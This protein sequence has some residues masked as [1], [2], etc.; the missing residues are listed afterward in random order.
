MLSLTSSLYTMPSQFVFLLLND[1][2]VLVGVLYNLY[3]PDL[4]PG[5]AH[6]SIGWIVT[7]VSTAHFIVS[8]IGWVA[9]CRR[10]HDST[11]TLPFMRLP[12]DEEHADSSFAADNNLLARRC[13]I[14][15]DSEQDA[16][17]NTDSLPGNST[18]SSSLEEATPMSRADK[19]TDVPGHGHG[20]APLGSFAPTGKLALRA[21]MAVS[22][23]LWK[24]I[25]IGYKIID[26]F[27]L[28]L[29]FIAFTTGIVT[30]GRFFVSH[31][32]TLAK[33]QGRSR[34]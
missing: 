20:R 8:M 23:R 26:R 29:G 14:S 27:I 16:G 19:E 1:T 11:E 28:P 22:S 10:G 24:H 18:S 3:T 33:S 2:G 13:R 25:G 21:T 34:R 9:R 12:T 31:P 7:W 4:Y 30:Y 17:P 15:N 6:H 32:H 5:N